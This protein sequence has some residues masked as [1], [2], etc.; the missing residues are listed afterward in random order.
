MTRTC[1]ACEMYQ[2]SFALEPQLTDKY[3]NN[4]QKS[5]REVFRDFVD[6]SNSLH[7]IR[8]Q[9][10]TP[11]GGAF[12]NH[13]NPGHTIEDMWFQLDA[14]TIGGENRLSD[15]A[16]VAK[17]AFKLGWDPLYG[18][19]FHFADAQSGGMPSDETLTGKD[20]PQLKLVMDDWSSKLWWVHA[21]ALYTYLRLYFETGD[22]EFLTIYREVEEYT[23]SVFPNPDK[24][25]GEWIQIRAR[26]G[27]PM[28]KVVA[29]P[30]KDPFHITRDFALIIDLLER[31]EKE[32]Y[33]D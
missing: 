30:V 7:E 12:G 17:H 1:L 21:E 6:S 15:I 9:D 23:F 26:D 4:V 16:A 5:S 33:N 32:D 10:G 29:L 25:V 11:V 22:R 19:L 13:I 27:S 2:D 18:G 3:M 20:E 31:A 24:S 14:S 28:D 8:Y